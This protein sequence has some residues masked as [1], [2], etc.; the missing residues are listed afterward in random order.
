MTY[1]LLQQQEG[2][3]NKSG[4]RRV[5]R[6][7]GEFVRR[8]QLPD[9]TDPEHIQAKVENGARAKLGPPL[10]CMHAGYCMA[11]FSVAHQHACYALQ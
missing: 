6:A 8:F 5:E 1:Y 7:F 11:H 3:D 2:D 9:N 10:P 4:Y